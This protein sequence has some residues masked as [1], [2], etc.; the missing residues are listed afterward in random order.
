MYPFEFEKR[1]LD[2]N[3]HTA[4]CL[5]FLISYLSWME[6]LEVFD[7][8]FLHNFRIRHN[9]NWKF[10][11]VIPKTTSKIFCIIFNIIF[12]LVDYFYFKIYHYFSYALQM[13]TY[14][15][16]LPYWLVQSWCDCLTPWK[17]TSS[18]HKLIRPNYSLVL[19]IY[20]PIPV[21]H[22]IH[23]TKQIN[24]KIQKVAPQI[25]TFLPFLDILK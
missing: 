8:N 25:V 18:G 7:C 14:P 19:N 11:L 1:L 15:N 4:I 24:W 20:L 16:T 22:R 3:S 10:S 13:N 2:L 21:S 6:L 9:Q 5:L 23:H 17:N 12:I